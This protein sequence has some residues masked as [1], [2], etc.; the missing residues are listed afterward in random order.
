MSSG[1]VIIFALNL[2]NYV[3]ASSFRMSYP[4]KWNT[5][6]RLLTVGGTQVH[7]TI[8][9][10]RPRCTDRPDLYRLHTHPTTGIQPEIRRVQN[11]IHITLLP[12]ILTMELQFCRTVFQPT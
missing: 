2:L 4:D 5:K 8:Y 10:R 3:T 12:H 11:A 7:Y 6:P 1:A 9:N